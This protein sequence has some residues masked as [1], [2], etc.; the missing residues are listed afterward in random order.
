MKTELIINSI[1]H[2]IKKEFQ[3]NK[4]IITIL[5]R[6]SKL[7][8]FFNKKYSDID[9]SIILKEKHSLNDILK[10]KEILKKIQKKYNIPISSTI[11][12]IKQIN[13]D[14]IKGI[15][16]HGTK[17]STYAFE[18]ASS[19]VILGK[20]IRSIFKR[21]KYYDLFSQY[22]N[23]CRFI[24]TFLKNLK[25]KKNKKGINFS[26][27]LAKDCLIRNGI[28]VSYKEEI[29]DAFYK[30][31]DKTFGNHLIYFLKLRE[32][33]KLNIQDLEKIYNFLVFCQNLLSK[34][35]N[36]TS[37]GIKEIPEKWLKI[38]G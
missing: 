36:S 7:P 18:I 37:K 12:N 14:A 38:Q 3:N 30:K 23:S 19:R 13:Q 35:I 24:A 11:I 32:K 20:D 33:E 21:M 26:F 9:L 1:S 16:F 17:D 10:I 2:D 15:H 27:I 4:I 25:D 8:E 29:A 22:F 31:I 5:L 6:G 28:R 34:G